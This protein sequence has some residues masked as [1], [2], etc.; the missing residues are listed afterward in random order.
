MRALRLLLPASLVAALLFLVSFRP[1]EA[2]S[3]VMARGAHVAIAREAAIIVWDEK[4]KVQHFIRRAAFDTKVPYFGFLVPT[5]AQPT[6]AEAPDALFDRLEDWTKP[7][8]VVQQVPRRSST[9]GRSLMPMAAAPAAGAVE[10]LDVQR[11][12]GYEAVVLRARDAKKLEE[13]L[14]KHG[15]ATR[16]ELTKWLEPYIDKGWIIT[17]FQIAKSDAGRPEVST[18]AVR[19]SFETERPFFPYSEPA[20]QRTGPPTRG[21]R[22]LRIFFV[23]TQRMQGALDDKTPWPG[24]AAWANPLAEDRRTAL[25]GLL[26]QSADKEG[27]KIGALPEKA[28]LTAFDDP[29]SPRPGTSDLFFSPSED[30]SN[31]HR[32]PIIHQV[33]VYAPGLLAAPASGWWTGAAVIGCSVLVVALVLV[34]WRLAMRA[35]AFKEE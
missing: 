16:P 30:Q 35:G 27:G 26:D 14:Q 34:G 9:F 13:W 23:G 32:P 19:M 3:P 17:A 25:Q 31:L 5:P 15:Y 18:Q 24:R 10:V 6:L 33:E 22:L 4:A 2:C 8:V 12:A 11:V 7:Q 29:S 1:A 28:H 21:G 20:D